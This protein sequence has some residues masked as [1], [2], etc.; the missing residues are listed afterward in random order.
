MGDPL[1][2]C[3]LRSAPA[4]AAPLGAQPTGAS[5]GDLAPETSPFAPTPAGASPFA[6]TPAGASPFALTPAGAPPFDPPPPGSVERWAYDLV[7]GTDLGRK[8]VPA[9]PPDAWQEGAPPRRLAAP[10]RP[11]CFV[12]AATSPRTP[13]RDALRDGRRRAQLYHTF[14]HHELQAAELMAWALLAFPEA[15]AA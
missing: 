10:G 9:P 3:S 4:G 12:V 5:P 13:G 6:P 7:V 15:P 8:L 11:S 2:S 14:L 1:F